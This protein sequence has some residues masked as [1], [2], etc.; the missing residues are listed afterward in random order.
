MIDFIV[1]IPF[2]FI[3]KIGFNQEKIEFSTVGR[4]VKGILY[5]ITVGEAFLTILE[6]LGYLNNFR[7]WIQRIIK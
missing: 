7:A 2:K 4:V 3:G 5:L 1:E 6:K